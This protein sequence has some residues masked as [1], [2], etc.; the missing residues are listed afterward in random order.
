L[1][2]VVEAEEVGSLLDE[3]QASVTDLQR[4]SRT[5]K[6][7]AFQPFTSAENALENMNAVSEQIVTQDLHNFLEM[8]LPKVSI[9]A[10]IPLMLLCG[11]V[12]PFLVTLCVH[13]SKHAQL[14]QACDAVG[15]SQ[16]TV[17]YCNIDTQPAVE[18]V[19]K[20]AHPY[21]LLQSHR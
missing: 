8:N 4:F 18:H 9:V 14:L 5:V 21:I 1:L 3:V 11:T 15:S 13:L 7:K 19:S 20:S 17:L 12:S 10:L 6:L 16:S 2:E